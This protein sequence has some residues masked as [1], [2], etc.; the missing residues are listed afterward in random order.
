MYN[1]K[2]CPKCQTG[3]DSYNIDNQST[4]CPYLEYNNG[5]RC[6]MYVKL[7]KKRHPLK[8]FI[9]V[10]KKITSFVVKK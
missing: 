6:E 10:I 9:S 2:L 7:K 8:C 5:Q 1:K 4:V 3:K